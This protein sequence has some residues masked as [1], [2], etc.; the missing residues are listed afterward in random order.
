MSRRHHRNKP[1]KT[2]P[3]QLSGNGHEAMGRFTEAPDPPPWDDGSQ[4]WLGGGPDDT[5]PPED[6]ADGSAG[7]GPGSRFNAL[8]DGLRSRLLFPDWML[9]AIDERACAF[10]AQV[11][12]RTLLEEWCVRE[13]ARGTVQ[14]DLA[15]DQLLINLRLAVER[16][17][18]S[19]WEDDRREQAEKLAK[20]LPTEP[21]RVAR[22]LARSKYG[23]LYLIDKLTALGDVIATN[24]GLND[25]Q[26]DA[27]LDALGIDHVVRDG[28]KV[29]AG[30]DGPGLAAVVEREKAR[31]EASVE[32]SLNDRD[33][34]EQRAA[35]IGIVR[36]HDEE[37][38][39]LKSDKSRAQRR[40]NW[41]WKTFLQV[42]A[43]VNPATII[44][45]ETGKPVDPRPHS[46]P[47][48]EAARPAP[49]PAAEPVEAPSWDPLEST[50]RH[51]SLSIL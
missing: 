34:S 30:N 40:Y 43:G 18:S 48:A 20:R 4:I 37:T 10:A 42:Q 45:P 7:A 32:R 47:A 50:C 3:S 44:D 25:S 28:C 6:E 22:A 41:A 38:R 35:M 13:M 15:S 23:A 2:P 9:R 51:A 19:R 26:R 8:Y 1:H 29:P 46:S 17:G 5:P 12:P 11:A 39:R 36:Q 33:R 31:L 21:Y 49:G 14:K 16:A 27:L 24:G